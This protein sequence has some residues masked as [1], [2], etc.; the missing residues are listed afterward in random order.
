MTETSTEWADLRRVADE[1][2]LKIHLASMEAHDRWN[3]LRQRLDKLEKSI[4]HT[5]EHAGKIVNE[6]V[7][8]VR[9]ALGDLRN[10]VVRRA[11]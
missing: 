2:E 4:A 6:E 10:E 11:R 5:R 1:I 8:A 7:S 9:K 3:A